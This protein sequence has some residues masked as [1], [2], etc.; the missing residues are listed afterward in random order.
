MARS[1]H[2]SVVG[3]KLARKLDATGTTDHIG[4]LYEK[5]LTSGQETKRYSVGGTLVSTRVGST[6]M[7]APGC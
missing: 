7:T 6:A 1:R 5:N 4:D 2:L 3:G